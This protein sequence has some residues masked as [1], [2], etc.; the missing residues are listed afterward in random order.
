MTQPRTTL[1]LVVTLVY[2]LFGALGLSDLVVC[3]SPD[4]H[5]AIESAHQECCHELEHQLSAGSARALELQSD[6]SSPSSRCGDCVDLPLAISHHD[7]EPSE[8]SRLAPAANALFA[9]VVPAARASVPPGLVRGVAEDERA[10]SPHLALS[11]G[12]LMRC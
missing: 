12:V 2:S 4:G 11:R 7:Q 6:H 1:A 10:R 8:T 9:A 3:I 5:V